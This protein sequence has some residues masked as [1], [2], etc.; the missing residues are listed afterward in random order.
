PQVTA[1][2]LDD[3]LSATADPGTT[4]TLGAAVDGGWWALG[5]SRGW[6]IDVFDGVPMSTAET[7]RR[8]LENLRKHGH[9]VKALPTLNDVDTIDDA[10]GAAALAP[11]GRFSRRLYAVTS[12]AS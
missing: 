9:Q 4:A 12:A 11:E 6:D 2:L 10:W 5:L 7:G 3:C 1:G 8:Q